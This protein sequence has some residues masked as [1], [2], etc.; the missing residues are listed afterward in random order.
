MIT[1]NERKVL[2]FLLVNF[3]TEHSINQLAKE[4]GLSPNGAYKILKKF[5]NEE[6]LEKKKIANISS[7]RID[8]SSYKAKKILEL[9]LM[10]KLEGKVKC[11]YEDIKPL[12][13]ITSICLIFGSYLKK[14]DPNDLDMF[15]ALEKKNFKKYKERLKSLQDIVP[16]KIHDLIQTKED[17]I[18]NLKKGNKVIK[19]A[20]LEGVV[21]W[22]QEELVEVFADVS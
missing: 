16:I 4:C 17:L 15:I 21:L 19:E 11:R 22:G 10:D 5:E 3:D 18:S 12:E 13:E 6:I 8:F 14:K 9:A 1:A 20:I 2:K 7:F